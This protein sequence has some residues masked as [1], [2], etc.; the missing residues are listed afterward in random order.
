[1]VRRARSWMRPAERRVSPQ[2]PFFRGRLTGGP[3]SLCRARF[4]V[5]LH[6]PRQVRTPSPALVIHIP[7]LLA[8]QSAMIF[9]RRVWR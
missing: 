7:R 2:G 4:C 1:M 8:R 6:H 9:S 3:E 5:A